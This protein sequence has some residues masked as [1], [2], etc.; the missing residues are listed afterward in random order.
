MKHLLVGLFSFLLISGATASEN[1]IAAVEPLKAA[2]DTFYSDVA[3][4]QKGHLTEDELIQRISYEFAPI[5]ND[6]KVALRVMGKYARQAS[7]DDRMR[8][9]NQLQGDL[10]DAYARGL[11]GYGGEQ[12]ILPEEAMIL[13][14]GRAIINAKLESPGKEDLPI[15]FAMGFD[16]KR[17]W[18]VENVVIAGINFGLTLRNQFADLVETKGNITAAIDA[19][20][21]SSVRDER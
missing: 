17:G 15:Q 11:A 10:V 21:F 12:L 18:L 9:I 3:L 16:E 7:V 5:I 19:W 4:F 8:F 13:K 1:P 14:R 2:R 6:R 20:S